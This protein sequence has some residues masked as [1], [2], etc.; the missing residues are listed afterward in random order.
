MQTK[1]RRWERGGARPTDA[2]CRPS[3]PAREGRRGV[4]GGRGCVHPS[5]RPP[6][7]LPAFSRFLTP[8]P[9]RTPQRSE[10]LPA[11]LLPG[12][13]KRAAPGVAVCRGV[14][15]PAARPPPLPTPSGGPRTA[16]Q[17]LQGERSRRGL[18]GA[19]LEPGFPGQPASPAERARG[20]GPRQGNPISQHR[21]PSKPAPNFPSGVGEP[22][23]VRGPGKDRGRGP[24]STR[25]PPRTLSP[26]P[27]GQSVPP[28]AGAAGA[29]SPAP[30][31][32]RSSPREAQGGARADSCP[33]RRPSLRPQTL[34]LARVASPARVWGQS[35][36]PGEP[37]GSGP[38]QPRPHSP[39]LRCSNLWAPPSR[40]APTT[41]R[42]CPRAAA[43]PPARACL[44][45]L[46]RCP[47]ATA[48]R[49]GSARRPWARAPRATAAGAGSFS[50]AAEALRHLPPD[51][52]RGGGC[53]RRPG[54]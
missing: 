32:P 53:R 13:R 52:R 34:S 8:G 47:S 3:S 18:G 12:R 42:L 15:V 5:T 40:S 22:G 54:A 29:T 21:P 45:A 9:G 39:L 35:G 24:D 19:A 51:V 1:R 30:E 20:R 10:A 31:P 50:A 48:P 27:P 36:G 23:A 38:V 49:P 16:P 7:T 46:L 25:D 4:E 26:V 33:R 14:R 11:L 2:P 41:V 37:L 6:N 43:R 28:D 44:P 17:Q